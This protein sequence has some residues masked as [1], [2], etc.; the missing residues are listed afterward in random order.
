MVAYVLKPLLVLCQNGWYVFPV[1]IL[2]ASRRM[3][4]LYTLVVC[5]C[6]RGDTQG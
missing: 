3:S 2:N 5:V 6:F 4:S 1:N